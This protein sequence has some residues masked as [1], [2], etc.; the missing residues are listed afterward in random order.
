MNLRGTRTVG[1]TLVELLV[2]IAIIATLVALLLPAI[3]ATR[4]AARRVVCQ[5]NLRQF[6]LA[7]HSFESARGTFPPGTVV[8]PP[9]GPADLHANANSLLMPYY[10][11]VAIAAQYVYERPYWEQP[12]GIPR[13]PVQIFSCPTNGHQ[14]Y[15]SDIFEKLGLPV[16]NTFATS[17]YAYCHG[18]TDAWCIGQYPAEEIGAFSIGPGVKL[19]QIADGTSHTAAMGEAAGG[20]QW[21]ICRGVACKEPDNQDLDAS[22]PWII[23]NLAADVMTPYISTSVYGSTI[24]PLNK[25]PVTNTMLAISGLEDCRSSTAGGP[26]MT[27]NFR[28]DHPGGA[29]FL[30]CDGSVHFVNEIV[31]LTTYRQ[32]STIAEGAVTSNR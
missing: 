8:R 12:A 17:D 22:Y 5:N 7:L 23:G 16:G 13:T 29:Q 31:D 15:V 11:E 4:E 21:P 18:A 32:L 1:F 6:G 24:E 3:Q 2:V 10:D 28:S 20:E 25:W 19:A 14:F 26:H 30:Y 27:S 9:F